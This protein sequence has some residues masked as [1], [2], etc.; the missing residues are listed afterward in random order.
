MRAL[1]F[2]LDGTLMDTVYAHVFASQRAFCGGQFGDRR[3]AHSSS[4]GDERRPLYTRGGPRTG[5]RPRPAEAESLQHPHGE[6]FA[7]LLPN[8]RPLPG[9]VELI[10]YLRADQILYGIATSGSRPE[11]NASL[12]AVGI[13]PGGGCCRTERCV[14]G[15]AGTGFVSGVPATPGRS[16]RGLLCGRRC[17]LGSSGGSPRPEC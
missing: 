8:R 5:P 16:P 6:L 3:L 9:A 14:A 15:Q 4:H 12:D 11:I 1:I 2:D 7:Q 17:D 10:H 13:G